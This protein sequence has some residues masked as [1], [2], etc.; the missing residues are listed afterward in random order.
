MY[1]YFPSVEITGRLAVLRELVER[2][3]VVIFVVLFLFLK[4]TTSNPEI[5][6]YRVFKVVYESNI[7][8][9]K[10]FHH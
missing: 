2:G 10:V 7:F 4:C 8:N 6:W 5:F 3:E 1:L 9:L